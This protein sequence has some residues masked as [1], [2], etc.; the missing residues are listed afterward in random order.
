MGGQARPGHQDP[1]KG[2]GVT[3]PEEEE[4]LVGGAAKGMG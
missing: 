3:E 2:Q 4:L 1:S